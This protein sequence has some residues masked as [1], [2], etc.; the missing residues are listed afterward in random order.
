MT[1]LMTRMRHYCTLPLLLL[2]ITACSPAVQRVEPDNLVWPL[3]PNVPRIKYIQSIYSEDDIGRVYTFKEKLF[4]KDY[5]DSIARPYGI[6]VSGNKIYMTDLTMKGVFVFDL[7]AKRITM[8]GTEGALQV[9][10]SAV[11]D[12]AGL[13]YVADVGGSKVAVYDA[14]GTYRTAYLLEDSRPVA[15]AVNDSLGR[16]YVVDRAGNRILV[17]GLDGERLLDFGGRGEADGEFN[18]P[19][20]I[21]LDRKGNVYVV[22]SGNFRVQIFTQDGKFISKFGSVGDH[23]GMFANPKGIAVDSENHIYVTDAAFSNFQIFDQQG[24]FLMFV[25]SM[26][27]NPGQMHL[28]GGIAIDDTDRIYL[29]DQFNRRIQVFQ[30]ISAQ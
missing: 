16:L 18:M 21:T 8:L 17:L 20:A 1:N 19:I 27:P 14:R 5:L 22:D 15:L 9:P 28:P 23:Q 24:N 7:A 10:A 30:Y 4:G 12:R 3:P 11:A 13:V 29:A 25:G 2:L 26:G 6:S